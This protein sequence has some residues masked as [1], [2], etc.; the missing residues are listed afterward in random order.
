MLP[1][2]P[3]D[4]IS[5]QFLE[6]DQQYLH[7]MMEMSA[8]AEQQEQPA[9]RLRQKHLVLLEWEPNRQAARTV[10]STKPASYHGARRG[11]YDAAVA[12]LLLTSLAAIAACIV[13]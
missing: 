2:A 4:Q 10:V 8:E 11:I 6:Q 1:N 9:I 7:G 3:W 12:L 5:G 13:Q